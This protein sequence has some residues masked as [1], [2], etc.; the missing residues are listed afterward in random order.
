MVTVAGILTRVCIH[1][2]SCW[3]SHAHQSVY[4]WLQLLGFSPECV[5]TGLLAC[6][7]LAW[8]TKARVVLQLIKAFWDATLDI[9]VA[10]QQWQSHELLLI[11]PLSE[12]V[13]VMFFSDTIS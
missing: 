12:E 9:L 4:P 3:D 11:M 1:G 8:H 6:P 5:P 2:Y 13:P 10:L 7:S